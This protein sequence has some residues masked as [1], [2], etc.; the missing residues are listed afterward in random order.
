MK[1]VLII[2]DNE[3]MRALERSVLEERGYKVLEAGN[4]KDGIA[5]ALEAVPDVILM[6]IRLPSKK[7]GIG[8]AKILRE[9]KKTRNVPIIFVTGYAE[10]KDSAEVQHITNCSYLTKPVK[11]DDLIKEVGK[12]TE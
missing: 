4:A 7:R 10:V 8:A 5:L 2:E 1:N 3:D 11:L 6:D 9:N 12:Y